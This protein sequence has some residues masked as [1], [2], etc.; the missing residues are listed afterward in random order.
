[1]AIVWVRED[2]ESGGGDADIEGR[3]YERIF[4]VLTD[5]VADGPKTVSEAVDPVS[6]LAVPGAFTVFAKGN[7]TD[8]GAVCTKQ[9]CQRNRQNPKLWRV[10]CTFT[11][12]RSE[13]G[14]W[15][16]GSIDL[17]FALPGVRMWWVG[18][19]EAIDK[20]IHGAPIVN[21]AGQ[22]FKPREEVTRYRLAIEVTRAVR[23]YSPATWAAYGGAVNADSAWGMPPGTLLMVAPPGGNRRVDQIGTY[24]EIRMEIHVNPD[25]WKRERLDQ[26]T[27]RLAT[28]DGGIP[29]H[30]TPAAGVGWITDATGAPVAHDVLL[31][32]AGLPLEITNPGGSPVTLEFEVYHPMPF[33]PLNLPSLNIAW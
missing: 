33:A 13:S 3:S 17:T 22:P 5:T 25:G 7:E 31:D 9:R 4:L 28:A 10:T 15:P 27:H 8:Y 30:S 24:Y 20:D 2:P 19:Q 26:G 6:G 21:S 23:S 12:L 18:Y 1:M 11:M 29:S 14:T 32:G 16:G